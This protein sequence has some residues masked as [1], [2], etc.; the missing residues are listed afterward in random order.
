M[1]PSRIHMLMVLCGSCAVAFG[2]GDSTE[3]EPGECGKD[4]DVRV[5]VG[6]GPSPEISWLPSILVQSVAIVDVNNHAIWSVG[7]ES[8]SLEPP[9]QVAVVLG[10]GNYT[11]Y[12]ACSY[13]D[14]ITWRSTLIGS[15]SFAR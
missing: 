13:S 11:A 9:V 10:A 5:S 4:S 2:C 12:I 3:P 14:G 15:K 1:K 8:N 6:A 7:S